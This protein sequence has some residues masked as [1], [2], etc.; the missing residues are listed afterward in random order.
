M[1]P[2]NNSLKPGRPA[3]P[4]TLQQSEKEPIALI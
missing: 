1:P 2:P 4:Q 3:D